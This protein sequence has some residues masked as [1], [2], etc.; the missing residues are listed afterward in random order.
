MKLRKLTGICLLVTMAASS[1]AAGSTPVSAETAASSSAAE[2]VIPETEENDGSAES[3]T[4]EISPEDISVLWE[5][6]HVFTDLSLGRY[7]TI[8]TYAVKGYEDVP[9]IRADDY[10]DIICEGKERITMENGILTVSVNGTEAVIDTSEDTVYFENPARFRSAGAVDG[11]IMEEQEYNVVTASLKNASVQG[12]AQPLTVSLRE[13]H[14][15]VLTYEDT[16]LMPF[17]ALQNT[18]GA[19]RQYSVL[20]YNGKDYFNAFMAEMY[21]VGQEHPEAADSPYI[22]AIFNG[23]FSGKTST[24]QA[25][26]DYGYYSVC[27]LLDLTFGHKEERNITTFDEFFTRMNAKNA[28]TSTDPSSAMT[29]E[30]LLFNYLFDS[31]HD[32]LLSPQNV[33]GTS[34]E[35]DVAEV[36]DI[37][38]DIKESEEGGKLFG[39]E[40]AEGL[41]AD[42][43]AQADMIL[44]VLMEKGLK[45]PE[46]APLLVWGFFMSRLKP[47]EYGSE[48][49]DF[50]GDTAVIY[51]DAFEYNENR[52]PSYYLDP[53]KEEDKAECTFAFFHEC[54]EEIGTHEEVKNVVIN[55]SANGGG[56]AA[57][58]VAVLGFLSEDGEVRITLRDLAAGNY[59]EE[60]YHVDTNLDGIPDDQ[61]GY[62]GQYEFYIMCSGSSYSCGTALPYFAQKNGL[63]AIIGS[64]PGGGD[65]VV[66]AFVDAYGR[67]AAYSGMLKLGE[68]KDGVFV[69]DEKDTTLDLN[70]MPSIWDIETVPW[71]DPDGIADAVHQYQ[72][73]AT[74]II[75]NDKTEKEKIED[76]L[77]EML[78]EIEAK[79]EAAEQEALQEEVL[80]EAA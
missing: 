49:L 71:Y 11:A 60:C 12:E 53:I 42:G 50:S 17:L 57:A 55:I 74:E 3:E 66:G 9:F 32:S 58:L 44:G 72:E 78:E 65:C 23:P 14:M 16:V 5:D 15:P 63:A 36:Q 76:L 46:I 26:A 43:K 47:D 37:V 21:A 62:G 7:T 35:S 73:G 56:S 48:R 80:E 13:Y 38:D 30:F 31:G 8:K 69:S 70:M 40:Q 52:D 68:E 34:T 39:D 79:M 51:F 59:K 27:L 28:M 22:N 18:F 67:C 29:A 33:F 10:L 2:S 24:T 45:I 19:M 77:R 6:S 41:A 1:A 75:Y 20:A 61:D 25:Y 54:F 64:R 4:E